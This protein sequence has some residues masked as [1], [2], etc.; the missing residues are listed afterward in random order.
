M[1]ECVCQV[2][3]KERERERERER[4]KEKVVKRKYF[5]LFSSNNPVWNIHL[6][7]HT[8]THSVIDRHAHA[9]TSTLSRSCQASRSSPPLYF[10]LSLLSLSTLL[11]LWWE[12]EARTATVAGW[13]GRVLTTRKGYNPSF[14]AVENRGGWGDICLEY[15]VLQSSEDGW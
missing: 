11:G 2:W 10:F 13:R 9:R 15:M 12:D 4:E 8:R 3:N 6:H 1:C 7:S 5:P 14:F